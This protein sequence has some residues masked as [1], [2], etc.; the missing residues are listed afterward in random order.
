MAKKLTYEFVRAEFEK[1]EYE[2]LSKAYINAHS[3]LKYKCPEGHKRSITWA[4]W[5]QGQ[6]CPH[7]GEANKISIGFIK[8]EFAKESYNLLTT[9]YINREQKLNCVCPHG[10]KYKTTWAYWKNGKRC[11]CSTKYR[12]RYTI[13]DIRA[14]FD[15]KGCKLISTKYKNNKQK[16]DYI[17]DKGHKSQIILSNL[18]K[19]V[20]CAQCA[21]NV[22]KDINY[23]KENVEYNNYKLVSSDYLSSKDKLHLICPNGHDYYVSWD[24]WSSKNHR[25]PKCNLAGTS[26]Q[27]QEL[28]EFIKSISFNV[29]ERDKSIISPYELDIVIPAKKIAIEYCGLYWHSELAGKDRRYHLNKL[30][31]CEKAGYRLITV[32]EDELVN[33]K[34]IV[35][36]RLKNLLGYKIDNIIYARQCSISEISTKQARKFCEENHLQ[37]YSGSKIK[38][39]AFHKNELVSVMTFSHGNIAKGSKNIDKVWELNRFCSK[40]G[41]RVV[42]IASKLLKYFERNY[43]WNEIFSYADRRWSSGDLYDIRGIERVHRFS[44]RKTKD[45]LKNVTEWEIRKSQGHNRIWDCGNLKYVKVNQIVG[46]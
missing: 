1:E 7:R 15:K 46:L 4:M 24:N 37:G 30:E 6:R 25:C 36:S 20:G 23:V 21:G 34:K 14:L 42:G 12:N 5:Q 18:L 17:C 45:D 27:E 22:K 19:G 10:N 11:P 43:A 8:K 2:L 3:K 28:V 32:F 26:K 16:L 13:E 31:M 41:C 29:I 44:L 40:V 39:G 35:F 33:N 9:R 38:L